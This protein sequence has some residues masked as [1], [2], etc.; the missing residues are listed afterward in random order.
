[1]GARSVAKGCPA[2]Q[3]DTGAGQT[4]LSSLSWAS[5]PWKGG[6]GAAQLLHLVLQVTLTHQVFVTFIYVPVT[7]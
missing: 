4:G 1:M 6:R 3:V 2:E 7:L 5:G